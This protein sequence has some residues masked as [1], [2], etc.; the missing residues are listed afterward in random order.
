MA[1][2]SGESE[3]SRKA[4]RAHESAWLDR[5]VSFG[6]V[7]HGV[8]HLMIAWLALQLAFGEKERASS[9]GALRELAQQ[10]WGSLLVGAIAV[11]MFVLVAARV[12]EAAVGHADEHGASRARK[13]VLSLAMAVVYGVLG[14]S[15]A[16]VVVGARGSGSGAE[17]TWT[18]RLMALPAGPVLVVAAGVA[19][20]VGGAVLLWRG[21]SEKFAEQLEAGARSGAQGRAYVLV[22]KV[23]H[24]AK[25]VAFAVVG[26]LFVQAGLR[27]RPKDAGGLDD[28]LQSVREQQFGPALLCVI[29]VGIACFGLYDFVRARHLDR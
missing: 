20:V 24:I 4:A 11:G 12:L 5:A 21:W 6:L 19:I 29:A 14:V 25:G 26:G 15:A 13:R 9:T 27:H 1:G 18:A 7:T 3:V 23:G 2:I 10:P 22:G 16:G 17:E 8:V 28:A